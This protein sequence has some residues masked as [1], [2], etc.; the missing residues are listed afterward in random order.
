[1]SCRIFKVEI[2]RSP[3]QG[4]QWLKFASLPWFA[5]QNFV[6][7][8]NFKTIDHCR[9]ERQSAK[10]LFNPF[11]IRVLRARLFWGFVARM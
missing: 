3:Y 2:L 8:R 4:D 1:M 10:I 6:V 9:S 11:A 5:E 7:F